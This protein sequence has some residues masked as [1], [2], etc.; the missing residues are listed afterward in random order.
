MFDADKTR[1]IG[2]PYGEKTYDDMLR[3]FHPNPESHESR[4]SRT[5]GQTDGQTDGRQT[6]RVAI[7]VLRVKTDER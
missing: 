4:K 5:D 2:L 6:D 7:S 3:H 1:T